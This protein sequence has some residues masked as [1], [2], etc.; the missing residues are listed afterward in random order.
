[1]LPK[2]LV[3]IPDFGAG[4]DSAFCSREKTDQPIQKSHSAY[5][6]AAVQ[7]LMM[8]LESEQEILMNIADMAMI[9]FP[10]RIRPSPADEAQCNQK[11]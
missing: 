3:S 5:A 7:K 6:G 10:C 1:M 9:T 2:E 11:S 4:D 8:K